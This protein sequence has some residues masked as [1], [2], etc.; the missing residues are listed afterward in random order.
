MK[1]IDK[2]H[3]IILIIIVAVVFSQ[4]ISF[5]F[6]NYDDDKL[7]YDNYNFLK[8]ISNIPLAFT[9][10]VFGMHG[11]TTNF[12][13]PILLVSYIVDY[14]LWKLAPFGYHLTNVIIHL[15]VS[16]FV[17][18]FLHSL[19]QE[20]FL[21]LTG[22]LIF[23]LHPLHTQTVAW[24]A[25]RN[26][27]LLGMFSILTL[28][29]YHE[30]KIRN[31]K[32]YFILS[33]LSYTAAIFTKEQAIFLVFSI[34][35]YDFLIQKKNDFRI[36]AKNLITYSH[37][38]S[39]L[40]LYFIIRVTI[41]G[42]IFGETN[43][44]ILDF[45]ARLQQLTYILGKYTQLILLP[46]NLNLIHSINT[47][48]Y[49]IIGVLVIILSLIIVY[50]YKNISTKLLFGFIWLF[51]SLL[52]SLN[53][54]PLPVPVLEHRLY[55]P[56][57]GF[58]IMVTA[59]AKNYYKN[60]QKI[61]LILLSSTILIYGIL[62]SLRLPV[63]KNSETLWLDVIKN[64]PDTDLPY[65]NLGTYYLRINHINKAI[66]YLNQAAEKNPA[67]KDIFQ[68][69][70]YAYLEAKN[71]DKAIS[72][73]QKLLELDVESEQA[74]IGLGNAFRFQK[75]YEIAQR[76]YNDGLVRLPESYKLHYELAL[77][78]GF[79]KEHQRAEYHLKKSIE[80]NNRYAAAYFG[81][82][83]LYSNFGRDSAAIKIFEEGLKYENPAPGVYYLLS[84]SYLNIG[85][86]TKSGYYLRLYEKLQPF[87]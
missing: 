30:F 28:Y 20:K 71:Y 64:K 19:F 5:N 87:K 26:D 31:E 57:I 1:N 13:R 23:S 42:S 37:Y 43:Y 80:L 16:I 35:L 44:E 41:F 10:N 76:I 72:A 27:L 61:V 81:L 49:A 4:T 58:S 24:I 56:I 34:P 3:G 79:M 25:A 32:K 73:Y 11:L 48:F 39:V 45:S 75:K 82:G 53:I 15:I 22:A 63:W 17:W 29:F 18:L 46:V 40:I 52:P 67:K 12:Y 70:G 74:Y 86:T 2:K 14:Q 7:V 78:Y 9:Q 59:F 36:N 51:I 85:D 83:G 21:S 47:I 50:K 8:Y 66:I 6:I 38:M 84:K 65:Y 77:C 68:N 54:F 69:L 62:C 60:N 33:L 55:T